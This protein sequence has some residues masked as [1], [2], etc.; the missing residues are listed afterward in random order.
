MSWLLFTLVGLILG[1]FSTILRRLLMQD[2][3]NDALASVVVFQFM[4]FGIVLIF[5]LL[6]GSGVP[7]ITVHPVNYLAQAILWGTASYCI[8]KATKYLEAAEVSII[9]TLS[10]IVT[11]ITAVVFLHEIF[12]LPRIIGTVL[13][14]AAVIMVSYKTQKFKLNKGVWYAL[15]YCLVSGVAI[16]ND[17]FL[18]KST[19]VFSLLTVGWLTPG[20]F[21]L[22]VQPRVI[23]KLGYILNWSRLKKLFTM[24]LVYA[25][26]GISFYYAI[27]VGGQASQVNT[28]SQSG[29][30]LT[31]L[32][33]ALFLNERDSL[34]KKFVSAFIVVLG[35]FLLS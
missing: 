33:G 32:L 10:S 7:D 28:I 3:K 8:F 6:N 13:I 14:I 29:I 26:G 23:K 16:T 9:A 31:T 12:T 35:V 22:I 4:G 21:L 30:I 25:L 20:I 15:M 24:T 34:G 11:I 18:L 1:S 5:A 17:T 2:D 27:A 19:G